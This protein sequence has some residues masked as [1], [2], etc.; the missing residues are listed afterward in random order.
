LAGVDLDDGLSGRP[1]IATRESEETEASGSVPDA[2]SELHAV[3]RVLFALE[4][5]RYKVLFMEGPGGLL[6]V[7]D[8]AADPGESHPLPPDYKEVARLRERAR[9]AEA[10]LDL[11]ASRLRPATRETESEPLDPEIERRLRALGYVD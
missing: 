6:Q 1:L 8:L 5:E 2:Y 3:N 7:Y 11:R 10:R 9:R 4:N